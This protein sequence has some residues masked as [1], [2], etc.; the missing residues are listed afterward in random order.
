VQPVSHQIHTGPPHIEA[1]SVIT[2]G[3]FLVAGF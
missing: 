3:N 2:W 1:T